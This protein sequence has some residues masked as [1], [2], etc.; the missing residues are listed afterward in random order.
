LVGVHDRTDLVRN[1]SYLAGL[2]ELH[3][4]A[5]LREGAYETAEEGGE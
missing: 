3:H 2:N 4:L 1:R 5:A